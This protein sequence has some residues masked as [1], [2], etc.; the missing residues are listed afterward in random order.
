V[1]NAVD[2]FNKTLSAM[3]ADAYVTPDGKVYFCDGTFNTEEI[4]KDSLLGHRAVVAWRD[5]DQ[6]FL[7]PE[8]W[9]W[10]G[11]CFVFSDEVFEDLR[12]EKINYGDG[13]RKWYIRFPNGTTGPDMDS[14]PEVFRMAQKYI[15]KGDPTPAESES[16]EFAALPISRLTPTEVKKLPD[17]SISVPTGVIIGK[18][19]KRNLNFW[20]DGRDPEFMGEYVPGPVEGSVNIE[21]S[22]IKVVPE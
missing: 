9:S 6:W 16:P 7:V 19:W 15:E 3:S 17:Y 22:K 18:C 5:G 21:W 12:I 2:T 20:Q 8:G 14:A 10:I 4:R 13:N 1:I 11:G